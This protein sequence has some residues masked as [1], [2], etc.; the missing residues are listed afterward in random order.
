MRYFWTF[1]QGIEDLQHPFVTFGMSHFLYVLITII[2]IYMIFRQYR[3]CDDYGKQKWLRGVAIYFLIEE[4]FYYL[5]II[6]QCKENFVFEVLSLELCSFCSLAN[7]LTLFHPNKQI[8]FFG[9]CIGL[10]GGPIALAYPATIDQ[11]YPMISYRSFNFFSAHG[12]YILFS[13]M[14]IHDQELLSKHRLKCHLCISGALLTFVYFFDLFFHTQYMF[15]GTPPQ[16]GIIRMLYDAVGPMAFFPCALLIFTVGQ[17]AVYTLVC[18]IQKKLY[19]LEERIRKQ[20]KHESSE[21][22]IR[23][24]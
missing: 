18:W 3:L 22:S 19:P 15:V 16:I 10:I 5:W 13:L 2:G 21:I 6:V 4:L 1:Y 20:E 11:L 12:A 9:A 8:R 24:L 23:G 14:L 7:L 17:V